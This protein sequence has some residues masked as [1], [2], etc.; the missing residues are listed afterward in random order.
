MI[1]RLLFTSVFAL[2]SVFAYSQAG[3]LRGVV[4]DT[5]TKEAVPLVNV[6]V[7]LGGRIVNGGTT[8]FRSEVQFL[9]RVPF[10]PHFITQ[11]A[12]SIFYKFNHNSSLY[13][14]LSQCN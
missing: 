13:G 4:T 3:S 2:M 5:D 7:K 10:Q 1:R 6:M 14:N 8:N 11:T 12:N 9:S